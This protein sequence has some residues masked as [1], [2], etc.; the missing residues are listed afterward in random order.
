ML[1]PVGLPDR[2]KV[3]EIDKS[4]GGYMTSLWFEGDSEEDFIW[5]DYKFDEQVRFNTD[6]EHT[7][8][9]EILINCF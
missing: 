7:K 6:T 9:S 2:Y 4:M 1:Y 8:L 3:I 5:Y